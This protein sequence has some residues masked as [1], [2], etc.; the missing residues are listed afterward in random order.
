M[1]ELQPLQCLTTAPKE[2]DWGWTHELAT[3]MFKCDSGKLYRLVEVE[4]QFHFNMQIGR[5]CSGMNKTI[6]SNEEFQKELKS[7]F[8]QPTEFPNYI[9]RHTFNLENFIHMER[10]KIDLYLS[11]V[12]EL[13]KYPNLKCQILKGG[14]GLYL[15]YTGNNGKEEFDYIVSQITDITN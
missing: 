10:D 5:Y 4:D 8:I 11:K 3:E 9:Y 7:G 6:E 1:K 12:E 14:L 13:E 2:Y 15:E